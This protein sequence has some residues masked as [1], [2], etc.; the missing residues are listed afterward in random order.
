M[1]LNVGEAPATLLKICCLKES[2]NLL[3]YEF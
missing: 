2:C 1:H 3:L